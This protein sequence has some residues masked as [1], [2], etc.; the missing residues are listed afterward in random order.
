MNQAIKKQFLM[1]SPFEIYQT[2]RNNF[3]EK[4]LKLFNFLTTKYGYDKPIHEE[5]KQ[6]DGVIITDDFRYIN[7]NLD[8]LISIS[9][10][11][12]SVDYGFAISFYKPSISTVYGK[13]A[14]AF[15]VLKEKQD[16]EQIY[17]IEAAKHLEQNFISQIKGEAW[18]KNGYEFK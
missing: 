14:M 17:L 2:K 4:T 6:D 11:Y 13:G 15:Y 8:R 3:I 16:I 7:K 9:N 18:L 5:G 10:S 12:H 1:L